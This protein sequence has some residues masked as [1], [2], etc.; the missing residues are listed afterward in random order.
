M[1]INPITVPREFEKSARR[2]P[3]T[4]EDSGEAVWLTVRTGL[5]RASQSFIPLLRSRIEGNDILVP[6]TKDHVKDA[7]RVDEDGH[8]DPEEEDRLFDHYGMGTTYT[9]ATGGTGK[10]ATW[11]AD[12]ERSGPAG[13]TSPAHRAPQV[14]GALAMMGRH[15]LRGAR[16]SA[17][18]KQDA[19]GPGCSSR[20]RPKTPPRT[21]PVLREEVRLERERSARKPGAAVSGPNLNEDEH[22][23]PC[24]RTRPWRWRPFRRTHPLGQ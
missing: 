5:F 4:Y 16:T 6:Y 22:R 23:S 10:T 3:E 11:S 17:T 13:G 19:G 12:E 8:L 14:C 15:A 2:Q 24:T 21:V 20:A 18:E 7:P 9:E 1:K